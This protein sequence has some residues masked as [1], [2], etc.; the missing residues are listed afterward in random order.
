LSD[1]AISEKIL[2]SP[3][4]QPYRD[5]IQSQSVK[6]WKYAVPLIASS[7]KAEEITL[8]DSVR[9]D[10]LKIRSMSHFI[11]QQALHLYT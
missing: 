7:S 4:L 3:L 8:E 1:E 11:L 2:S 5:A 10:C 9:I 6:K